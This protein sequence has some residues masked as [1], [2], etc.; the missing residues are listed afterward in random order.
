MRIFA[1]ALVSCLALAQDTRNFPILGKVVRLDPA[2]DQLLAPDAKLEV[3]SCCFDWSEGPVW[4]RQGGFLL[5]SDIPR[6]SVMKWKE[7]EGISVFLKPSGYTG[8]VPYGKEPGSNGLMM[9]A[10]G[11][12]YSAEHGDRRISVMY[13]DGGKR[14]LA[15][16][17]QGKRLNSPNDLVM[18]SSGDIYFTDPPYGLP[19][20]VNDSRKEIDFQGVYKVTP[21]GEVTLLTKEMTRP[22]RDCFFAG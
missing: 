13:R 20:N 21:K 5:F 17:Y 15:D 22:E 11:R 2:L 4:D 8:A 12:L 9:D 7:G 19:D 14:T 18:H 6:N 3:I 16:S 1:F 10:Q